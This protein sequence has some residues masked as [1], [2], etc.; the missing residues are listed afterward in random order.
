MM[1]YLTRVEQ[2]CIDANRK[3][4]KYRDHKA[5]DNRKSKI[6]KRHKP[7]GRAYKKVVQNER[8]AMYDRLCG[9]VDRLRIKLGEIKNNA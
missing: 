2:A 3:S 7:R 6:A 4:L 1:D 5:W 8:R 9:S